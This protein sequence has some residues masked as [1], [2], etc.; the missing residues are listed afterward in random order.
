MTA[1]IARNY[2][3]RFMVFVNCLNFYKHSVNYLI[4]KKTKSTVIIPD[5]TKTNV[6]VSH[7]ANEFSFY[8]ILIF[9]LNK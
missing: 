5:V 7:F 3:L 9:I 1:I 6:T 4:G 8:T 2:H